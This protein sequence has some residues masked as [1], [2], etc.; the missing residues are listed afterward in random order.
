MAN[1]FDGALILELTNTN[2]ALGYDEGKDM[3]MRPLAPFALHEMILKRDVP[4]TVINWVEFW[5]PNEIVEHIVA[6]CNKHAV[7]RPLV[8]CS[9]LFNTN[10]FKNTTV[11]YYIIKQLG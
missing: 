8:L 11:T 4:S 7:K 2:K 5:E 1:H 9:T 6:W 10:M 3:L